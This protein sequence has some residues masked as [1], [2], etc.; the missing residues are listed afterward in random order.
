MGQSPTK[1]A[2]DACMRDREKFWKERDEAR[3]KLKKAKKEIVKLDEKA[4]E[5]DKVLTA[6]KENGVKDFTTLSTY[7]NSL[8]AS[9]TQEE[10][11]LEKEREKCKEKIE[12]LK[13]EH[14]LK[15][16]LLKKQIPEPKKDKK[17]W[18]KVLAWL[19][20]ALMKFYRLILRLK[21]R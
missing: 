1:E 14:E 13:E 12:K 21:R 16:K 20:Q 18:Q 7:I 19:K 5:W 15:V 9:S 8:G 17:I 11:L 4:N 10:G 6:Y 3:K 2:Y